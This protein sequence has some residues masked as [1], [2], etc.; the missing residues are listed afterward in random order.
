MFYLSNY[1]DDTIRISS[2]T[3]YHMAVAIAAANQVS[4]C[5]IQDALWE[6]YAFECWGS[7]LSF[8]VVN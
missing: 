4:E 6:G 2:N 3:A 8:E 1:M 5:D 7:V